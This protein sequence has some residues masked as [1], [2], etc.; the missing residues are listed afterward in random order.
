MKGYSNYKGYL[1]PGVFVDQLR[2]VLGQQAN[3]RAKYVSA[4]AQKPPG[5]WT[6]GA[7]ASSGQ[8]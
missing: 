1:L 7:E 4:V 6:E 8:L 5:M 3:G 2:G